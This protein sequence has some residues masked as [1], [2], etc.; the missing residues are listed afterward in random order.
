MAPVAYW[1]R[2]LTLVVR[3]V[4]CIL[5]LLGAF[6][7]VFCFFIGRVVCL[8]GLPTLVGLRAL[9]R[10]LC[11]FTMSAAIQCPTSLVA[12]FP[13]SIY[14]SVGSSMVLPELLRSVRRESLSAV[15]FLRSGAVRLTFKEV[16]DCDSVVSTGL[17]YGD[18]P[19]RVVGVE[20]RSRLVY[21]RDCPAEVP[22]NVVRRFFASYGEVHSVSLGE[23]EGFPG[24]LN[25]N[26]VVKMSITK[27]IP[28]SVRVAGFDCRVWYRR[29]PAFCTICKKSGHRGKS[30]PLSGL[31]RRCRQPGHHA[32]ECRNAWGSSNAPVPPVVPM[33]S[34]AVASA[35]A[36]ANAP[37]VVADDAGPA[38]DNV[39]EVSVDV[40]PANAV[41]SLAPPSTD[42]EMSDDSSDDD[43]MSDAMEQLAS[44]DEELLAA[45][46]AANSVAE[47]LGP[48]PRRSKRLR[49][50]RAPP[51]NA[52]AASSEEV[53]SSSVCMDVS[54]DEAPSVSFLR[55]HDEVWRDLASWEEIRAHRRHG[56]RMC[57]AGDT[58]RWLYFGSLSG[59]PPCPVKS[60]DQNH[61]DDH[62]VS[63]PFKYSP[64]RVIVAPLAEDGFLTY[65]DFGKHTR[66]VLDPSKDLHVEYCRFLHY[67]RFPESRPTYCLPLESS[68]CLPDQPSSVVF[69]PSG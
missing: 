12:F 50:K 52:F 5:F 25:G 38:V 24:L 48:G 63:S 3:L 55:T 22:D 28:G 27:D 7:D 30:C 46:A 60:V 31:C 41:A 40:P 44:G 4:T 10:F 6:C 45:A 29:Q 62:L 56:Y 34:S 11:L 43:E 2:L 17:M 37:A 23:H 18:V 57:L 13:A 8:P 59:V 33:S 47:E 67:C 64:Y 49:E 32:R 42:A 66:S 51:R 54:L 58:P 68:P 69:G 16:T 21:L 20:T 65:M 35:G 39:A 53:I 14:Q 61:S 15:Q 19:L 9:W 1:V 36:P 26:R